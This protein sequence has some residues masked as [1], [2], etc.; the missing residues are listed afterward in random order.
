[1]DTKKAMTPKKRQIMKKP[2]DLYSDMTI[3][4]VNKLA[5][6]DTSKGNQECESKKIKGFRERGVM[7]L[8]GNEW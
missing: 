5:Y 7:M 8:D 3:T 4:E 2:G 1:M 6:Q